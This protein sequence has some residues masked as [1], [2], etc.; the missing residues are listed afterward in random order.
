M[1]VINFIIYTIKS[2]NYKTTHI[3]LSNTIA[4]AYVSDFWL[5]RRKAQNLQLSLKAA[6]DTNLSSKFLYSDYLNKLFLYH[7]IN[8]INYKINKIVI[9]LNLKQ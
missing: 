1:I 9:L 8:F 4:N 6:W 5:P 2:N 3:G 7:T